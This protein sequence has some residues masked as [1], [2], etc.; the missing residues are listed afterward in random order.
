MCTWPNE[1]AR[2]KTTNEHQD[3]PHEVVAETP[4]REEDKG[5]PSHAKIPQPTGVD[6]PIWRHELEDAV[7]M[8]G[9]ITLWIPQQVTISRRK[10]QK[11]IDLVDRMNTNFQGEMSG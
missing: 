9:F 4:N 5:Y 6:F 11:G 2:L 10:L 7:K 3:A 1:R 8:L